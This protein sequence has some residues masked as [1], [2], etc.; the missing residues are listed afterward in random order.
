MATNYYDLLTFSLTIL[1]VRL[2]LQP[3][4][5][6]SREQRPCSFPF[7]VLI[8]ALHTANRCIVA[9]GE[10]LVFEFKTK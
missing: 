8:A 3:T 7:V 1:Y 9:H 2:R 6:L 5:S 10:H 4:M